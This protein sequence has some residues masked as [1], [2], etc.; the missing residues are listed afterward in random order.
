M[1]KYVSNLSTSP[2]KFIHN[3]SP[4]PSLSKGTLLKSN[5]PELTKNAKNKKY[6]KKQQ[7][8]TL[9]C[10]LFLVIMYTSISIYLFANIHF[11]NLF[12]K[13]IVSLQAFVSAIF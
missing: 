8:S 9:Y 11:L 13:Y 4:S 10:Y 3:S 7:K 6:N 1:S 5:H 2:S 12:K